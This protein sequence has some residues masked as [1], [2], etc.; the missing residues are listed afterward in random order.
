MVLL[1]LTRQGNTA[2][3]KS[4]QE[5]NSNQWPLLGPGASKSGSLAHARWRPLVGA[6]SLAN[7]TGSGTIR[8]RRHPMR[9]ARS[10]LAASGR[11][12][13]S[14]LFRVI[15][16]QEARHIGFEWDRLHF[17]GVVRRHLRHSFP[18]LFQHVPAA[19][20]L[21]MSGAGESQAPD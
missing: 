19:P 18:R 21:S 9:A 5:Q 10:R 17:R 16:L 12:L 7:D 6:R 20:R 8:G 3:G 4:R 11:F 2:G 13:R 15:F 14:P 1:P